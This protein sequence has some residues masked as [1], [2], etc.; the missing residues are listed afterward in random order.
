M[1][2]EPIQNR[3]SPRSAELEDLLFQH[4]M[5]A[6]A[7]GYDIF[8][9]KFPNFILFTQGKSEKKKFPNW[10]LGVAT[11]LALASVMPIVFVAVL[12]KLGITKP[13]VDYEAGSPLKRIETNASSAPMMPTVSCLSSF[14]SHSKV[15]KESRKF[16]LE[17]L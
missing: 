3:V 13:H 7:N 12:R 14:N 5:S 11:I 8:F 6:K 17:T 2:W 1:F 9:C 16:Q 10:T 4:L 15:Q